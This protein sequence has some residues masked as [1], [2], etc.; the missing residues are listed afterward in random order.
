MPRVRLGVNI[1]HIA[2]LREVRKGFYPDPVLAAKLCEQSGADSI[3]CHLREDRRHIQEKDV[4]RLLRLIRLPL[5]LEMSMATDIVRIAR[6][7]RPDKVTLVPEKRQELTTEGGLD[8]FS[9]QGKL[10]KLIA[11]LERKK[12]EVSL[13]IDPDLKQLEASR[14]IG[15]KTIEFHTG[16]Y[17][18][19]ASKAKRK[20]EL[21][22]LAR[23]CRE[24][25][26]MGFSVAAGHGLNGQNVGAVARI[27]EIQELNIG[28]SIVSQ[29]LF[30]GLAE[31]VRQ[32]KRLI[33]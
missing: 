20:E 17:A 2:T 4:E 16:R 23:Y 26:T 29:A 7:L 12:I 1:D 15:A 33:R 3:V 14:R 5:N 24:A 19:A 21:G 11:S 31:A 30:V 22:L 13:F 32:M 25:E 27:P 6:R 10:R 9:H 28:H 8:V 18:N